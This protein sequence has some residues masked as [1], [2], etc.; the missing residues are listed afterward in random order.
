MPDFLELIGDWLAGRWEPPVARLV[1][2]RLVACESGM[3]RVELAAEERHHNPM[4]TVHGGILCDLADAAMGAALASVLAEGEG[5]ATVALAA[6]YFRPVR[7]GLLRA[8]GR[9]VHRGRSLAHLEAE[10]TDEAGRPV[11]AFTGT[12]AIVSVE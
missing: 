1:G 11:A 10:I 2:F 12:C 7:E 9:I 6:S 3:A 8:E 5:F 4:G